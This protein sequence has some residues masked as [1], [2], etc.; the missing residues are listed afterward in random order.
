MGLDLGTSSLKAVAATATGSIAAAARAGY[1]TSR[2]V[3]SAAEQDPRDWISALESVLAQ[4][5]S[6]IPADRWRCLSLTAMMPTLVTAATDGKPVG[7]AITWEDDR[8]EQQGEALQALAGGGRLYELT[9]QRVDGRYLLPMFLRASADDPAVAGGAA[10]LLSAKDY[11]FTWLTGEPITDPSTAAGF[12]CYGLATGGWLRDVIGLAESLSGRK[13]PSLPP[14]LDSGTFRPLAKS[15]SI[16]LGIPDGLPVCLG[17]AD[18]VMGALGL[19]LSKVG[20]VAYLAGTSTVILAL[21]D[22]CLLD[23]RHRFLVTPLAGID[24]FGLEMDILSTGSAIAWLEDLLAANDQARDGVMELAGATEPGEGPVVLPYLALGEQ[25]A[26]WD[27][28]LRGAILGLH[29]G[30]GASHIARGLVDGILLESRRCLAILEEIGLP[31]GEV[32]V[33]GG[34]GTHPRFVSDLADATGRVVLAPGD[35]ETRH[36]ALGAAALAA[37]AMDG[38]S[39]LSQRDGNFVTRVPDKMRAA[40]YDALSIRQ[41]EALAA[42]KAYSHAGGPQ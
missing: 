9:G 32:R 42:V 37:S 3:A 4:L 5:S 38:V 41:D 29:L 13:L 8:A 39:M 25:G 35:G 2:P 28:S 1:A 14:V 17:G 34:A 19:G 33:T 16:R 20:D 21:S 40:S 24:G 15:A 30:H 23:P 6:T 11:L 7:P 36:S 12:G 22:H 10:W 31:T 26:L 18:S 27:A